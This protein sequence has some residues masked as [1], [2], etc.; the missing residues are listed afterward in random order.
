MVLGAPLGLAFLAAT[1]V[2][3]LLYFLRRQAR[4]VQISA[5]FLW[6]RLPRGEVT[7]WE[8]L[9]PRLDLLLFLQLLAVVLFSLAAADPALVRTRPAGATLVVLDGSASMCAAGLADEARARARA[10]IRATAGP[11]ALVAWRRPLEVLTP[12]TRDRGEALAALARYRPTLSARPPLGQALAAFPRPWDRIVVI[13]DDPPPGEGFQVVPL[14][15]PP[16]YALRAFSLRPQPDGSGYQVLVRVANE[17][18]SYADLALTIQAGGSEYMKSLLVPPGGEETFVL[19]YQGPLGEGLVAELHPQDAFPWDNVRYFAPGLGP[20]RVRWVGDADPFLWAALTAAVP[21]VRTE[22]PPWDLTVAV[23]TELPEDPHG[24]ALLVAAGTPEAP[25]GAALPAQ[26]WRQ[27]EDPLLAHL[28]PEEWQVGSVL[29]AQLP[30]GARVALWS[31]GLPALAR[32]ESPQGRRVLLALELAGSGLPLQVDFPLLVRNALLWL[33]PWEGGEGYQVG[34]AVMLPPAARVVTR[35]GE[36]SGVWVPEAPG[37]YRVLRE[38]GEGWL[39]V[40]LPPEERARPVA[41]RA[42][43]SPTREPRPLWPLLAGLALGLLL[44][45]GALAARRG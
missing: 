21:A 20:V 14:A 1:T 6:E 31:G 45:E 28:R 29:P 7:H 34:E 39:A 27:E 38:G 10:A 16:N 9:W 44:V 30:A 36:I 23:R 33:L 40:N 12:P 37:L 5:L 26:E 11:W 24:P 3:V 18:G 2:V 13:S 25:V 32:W 22:S 19:P 17:T 35:E 15:S 43:E 8:R 41:A 4:K 42:G